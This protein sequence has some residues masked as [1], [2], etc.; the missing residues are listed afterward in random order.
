LEAI[1]GEGSIVV[2]VT[3]L[4]REW[5]TLRVEDTGHGVPASILS[6]LGEKGV[7]FGK[8]EGHGLGI[9]FAKST[10][11]AWGGRF[12]ID[13]DSG[14][15]TVV[16]ITL[17]RSTP[18]NW[19]VQEITIAEGSMVVVLDDDET[20]HRDW[21]E[22]LQQPQLEERGIEVVSFATAKELERWWRTESHASRP[23]LLL[24]DLE[25]GGDRDGLEVIEGLGAHAEAVV[26]T[27]AFY[28]LDVQRRCERAGV[29]LMAKWLIGRLPIRSGRARR[30]PSSQ[31]I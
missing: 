23:R 30:Q 21:R 4:G 28:E 25:L 13:S 26:V 11:E 12:Q 3:P 10:V 31:S 29:K 1:S 24:C 7:T 22:V 6:R 15:G 2:S 9:Y 14:S 5:V 20:V 18:P 16:E 27:S 8:P 19:Y 17:P